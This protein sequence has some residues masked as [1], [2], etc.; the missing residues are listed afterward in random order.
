[1]KFEFNDCN[2]CINPKIVY[3]SKP[4]ELAWNYIKIEIATDGNKWDYGYTKIGG[5]SPCMPIH[6]KHKTEKE[7]EYESIDF[8][9]ASCL[10][11]VNTEK[12]KIKIVVAK[13]FLDWYN[14]RNQLSLF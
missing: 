1:M 4:H 6:G 8:M 9:Y 14:G 13:Q 12:D 5:G 7:C 3:E 11:I 10:T 2:V